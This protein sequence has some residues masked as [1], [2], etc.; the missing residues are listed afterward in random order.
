MSHWGQSFSAQNS[1]KV[2]LFL[3]LVVF[4][5]RKIIFSP[6]IVRFTYF[7]NSSFKN[8]FSKIH[9]WKILSKIESK[10][11]FT[12][13]QNRSIIRAT[14]LLKPTN[15][16]PIRTK[17]LLLISQQCLLTIKNLSINFWINLF[18]QFASCSLYILPNAFYVILH[19]NRFF[20]QE[21]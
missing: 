20:H 4:F 21:R 19:I 3:A 6:H 12:F 9:F 10:T 15:F 5:E 13:W 7:Q 14:F 8:T 18:Q 11:V 2:E 16:L 17:G 1:F